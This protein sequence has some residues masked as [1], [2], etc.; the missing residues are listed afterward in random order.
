MDSKNRNERNKCNL[1]QHEIDKKQN[2]DRKM[3]SLE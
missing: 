1:K 2:K 3:H